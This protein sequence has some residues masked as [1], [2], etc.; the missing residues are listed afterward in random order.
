MIAG[1]CPYCNEFIHNSIGDAPCFS[2]PLCES[3]GKK[4]ALKHSRINPIAMTMESFNE[5]YIIDEENKKIKDK[6]LI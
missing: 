4:Y 3:C 5:K 1:G 6:P 2:F